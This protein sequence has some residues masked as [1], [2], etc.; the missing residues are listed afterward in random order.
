MLPEVK[1]ST[2][3]KSWEKGSFFQEVLPTP[4]ET[5]HWGSETLCAAVPF[6]LTEQRHQ[7]PALSINYRNAVMLQ[8]PK[9]EQLSTLQTSPATHRCSCGHK[10]FHEEIQEES[11]FGPQ[12]PQ[13]MMNYFTRAADNRNGLSSFFC[14]TSEDPHY[15]FFQLF[16][17]HTLSV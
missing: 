7:N 15:P 16:P 13:E 3:A 12:R 5:L 8:V 4:C 17:S 2:E 6:C 10:Y 11:S 14:C 9:K 1:S